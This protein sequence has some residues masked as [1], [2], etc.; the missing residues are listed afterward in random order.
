MAGP[1]LVLDLR[2]VLRALVDIV[3]H[4]PDR[5][6]GRDLNGIALAREDARDDPHLVRLLALGGEARLAGPPA[7][8]LDLDIGFGQR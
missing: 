2:I 8:E 7:I 4:Q 5:G 6:P 1:V 3:D